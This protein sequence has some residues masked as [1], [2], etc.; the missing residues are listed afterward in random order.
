MNK[1]KLMCLNDVVIESIYD[2]KDLY[3]RAEKNSIFIIPKVDIYSDDNSVVLKEDE[4]VRVNEIDIE[5]GVVHIKDGYFC[6][7]QIFENCEF[8]HKTN[9]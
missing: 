4:A 5:N 9:P 2:I 7:F 8:K 1:P 6:L 3:D